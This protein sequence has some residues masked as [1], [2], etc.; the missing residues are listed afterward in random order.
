MEPNN[1][2]KNIMNQSGKGF[3]PK[4]AYRIPSRGEMK[5]DIL[6]TS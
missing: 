4:P 5:S 1:Y 2:D 6:N 3:R